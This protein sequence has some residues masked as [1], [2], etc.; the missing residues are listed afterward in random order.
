MNLEFLEVFHLKFYKFT[1]LSRDYKILSKPNR[2]QFRT[3]EAVC[4][5]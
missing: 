3:N 2:F 4:F 5:F 1:L